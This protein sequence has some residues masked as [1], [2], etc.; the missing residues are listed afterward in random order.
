[1]GLF[2][3]QWQTAKHMKWFLLVVWILPR[4]YYALLAY[5]WSCAPW[6]VLLEWLFTEERNTNCGY[7]KSGLG[8]CC[9]R[10]LGQTSETFL[11]SWRANLISQRA[12]WS[13]LQEYGW[14][15]TSR[16][17][18]HSKA[19][20]SSKSAPRKEQQFIHTTSLRQCTVCRQWTDQS[21]L[22]QCLVKDVSPQ[23]VFIASVTW[24]GASQTLVSA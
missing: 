14:G 13:H 11:H 1:M 19:A 3:T 20:A 15:V 22:W 23:Q 17:R 2:M 8:C 18:D 6:K 21:L 10:L 9:V 7:S 12:S 5:S 16:S 24:L 4:D